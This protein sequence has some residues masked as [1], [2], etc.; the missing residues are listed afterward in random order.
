MS[1]IFCDEGD[2]VVVENPSYLGAFATILGIAVLL[3]AWI[4]LTVAFIAMSYAYYQ[5]ISVEENALSAQF[6]EHYAQYVLKRK[7]M[8]PGIW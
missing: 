3:Q 2:Y 7:K 1:K 6:G 4:G 8:L 5:R